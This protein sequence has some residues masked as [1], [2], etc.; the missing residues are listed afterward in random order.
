MCRCGDDRICQ[1]NADIVRICLLRLPLNF[2]RSI[3][4]CGSKIYLWKP[5][6]WSLEFPA[7]V[8]CYRSLPDPDS[9][10]RDHDPQNPPR[11]S[12]SSNLTGFLDRLRSRFV[13]RMALGSLLSKF[14]GSIGVRPGRSIDRRFLCFCSFGVVLPWLSVRSSSDTS[15]RSRSTTS[16]N[17]SSSR[18][19]AIT[20]S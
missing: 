15:R 6:Q 19:C 13:S 4:N 16:E 7:V 11:I 17:V 9:Q 20:R 8:L 1:S 2:V 18:F 5:S 3:C 10:L 12:L 14:L